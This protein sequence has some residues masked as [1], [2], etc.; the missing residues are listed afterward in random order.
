MKLLANK[1]ELVAIPPRSF[2]NGPYFRLFRDQ[3]LDT[4]SLR[5]LHLFDSRS[6]AFGKDNVLQENVIFHTVKG[7]KQKQEVIVSNSSGHLSAKVTECTV[8]YSEVIAPYDPERFIHVDVGSI[9][10]RL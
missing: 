3:L 10:G 8:L 9:G 5:R 4:M 1:G 2:C 7:E 6:A